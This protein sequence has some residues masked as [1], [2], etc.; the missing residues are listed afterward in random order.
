MQR[1][2][3]RIFLV[4]KLKQN[5]A[6]DNM[7]IKLFHNWDNL[8]TSKFPFSCLHNSNAYISYSCTYSGRIWTLA[9][10]FL[11]MYHI[12]IQYFFNYSN[13]NS[14]LILIKKNYQK[15]ERYEVYRSKSSDMIDIQC[16][17]IR[18]QKYYHC[19]AFWENLIQFVFNL[20]I[21]KN[22]KK[23]IEIID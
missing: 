13:V 4:V 5:L 19:T 2:G 11:S 3:H 10:S 1:V 17:I 9:S 7:I 18:I 12:K 15:A 6:D 14:S 21:L 22:F 16:S 23:S 8:I 20:F